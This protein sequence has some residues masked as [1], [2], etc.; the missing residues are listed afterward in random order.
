MPLPQL[1][2]EARREALEKAAEARRLRADHKHKLKSGAVSL[3]EL[4]DLADG[5]QPLAKMRVSEVIGAM[6]GYGKVRARQLMEE[7]GISES[8]RVRGLGPNQR[9]ALLAAFEGPAA[10]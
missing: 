7:L 4:L 5:E 10:S 9:A 3:R 6:P 2:P 1:D 8:R